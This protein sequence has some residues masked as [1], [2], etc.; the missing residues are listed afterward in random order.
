MENGNRLGVGIRSTQVAAAV[1]VIALLAAL[2]FSA[3]R[4]ADARDR[5]SAF[6][7]RVEATAAK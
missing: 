7:G 3:F 2:G 5:E 6:L 4:N 1:V